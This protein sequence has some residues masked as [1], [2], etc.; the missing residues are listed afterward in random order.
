[1]ALTI[2]G[3]VLLIGLVFLIYYGLTLGLRK[4]SRPGAENLLKCTLCQ[5]RF[6]RTKLIQKQVG[7]SKLFYF[8]ES[9]VR[10]LYGELQKTGN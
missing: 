6:D 2:G 1:M 10:N 7:D 8:C 5:Q 3:I 4:S 9:C